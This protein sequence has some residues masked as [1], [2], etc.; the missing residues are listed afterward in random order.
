MGGLLIVIQP[1]MYVYVRHN[2]NNNGPTTSGSSGNTAGTPVNPQEQ[3]PL[4]P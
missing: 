1:I 3:Q 2:P 4:V